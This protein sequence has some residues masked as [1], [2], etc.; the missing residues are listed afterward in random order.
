M[1]ELKYRLLI[2]IENGYFIGFFRALQY[3]YNF[4]QIS[5]EKKLKRENMRIP[6]GSTVSKELSKK[7]GKIFNTKETFF[8]DIGRENSNVNLYGNHV[9]EYLNEKRQVNLK[10]RANGQQKSSSSFKP[11]INSKS[12]QGSSKGEKENG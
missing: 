6:K 5:Y 11:K 8:F 7:F 2:F 10:E 1:Q 4:V 12:D 3:N 9:Q